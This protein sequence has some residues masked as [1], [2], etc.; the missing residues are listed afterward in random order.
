MRYRD[1]FILNR[2]SDVEY[3]NNGYITSRRNLNGLEEQTSKFKVKC[4]KKTC[5]EHAR[6]TGTLLPLPTN[7]RKITAKQKVLPN[8]STEGHRIS[9]ATTI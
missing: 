3:F 8:F 7:S 1:C 9:I 6:S 5:S 4:M 2:E